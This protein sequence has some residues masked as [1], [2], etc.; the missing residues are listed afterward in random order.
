MTSTGER[1]KPEILIFLYALPNNPNDLVY[2]FPFY[3]LPPYEDSCRGSY[4]STRSG[5]S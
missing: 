5:I 1:G 3:Y 2:F 4:L